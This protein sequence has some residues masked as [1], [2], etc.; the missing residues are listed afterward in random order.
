MA[1][2]N[3]DHRT[4]NRSGTTNGATHHDF[5]ASSEGGNGRAIRSWTLANHD[6]DRAANRPANDHFRTS[7]HDSS[8]SRS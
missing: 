5:R 1:G 3:H 4:T 6:I 7:N 2:M 8:K